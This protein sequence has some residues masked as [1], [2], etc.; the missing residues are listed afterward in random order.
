MKRKP[1]VL[2]DAFHLTNA[3]TG[4]RTY[5]TQLCDGI[6]KN[7]YEE[8]E[9]LI[10]PNWR[11]LNKT[12]LLRGKVNVFKKIINHLLYLL[13]KQ[14]CLPLI[15]LF[16]RIDVIVAPDYLLPFFKFKSKSLAVFH[17]T[18]YWELKQNYNPLWRNYF[19]KSVMFGL[20]V[21]TGIVVTS[22]F[23]ANKVEQNVSKDYDISV[24]YQAPKNLA[25]SSNELLN[26]KKIGLPEHAKYFLH[27]GVL[28]KRKN[29][30]ILITA[31]SKICNDEFF[32]D[33]H[34]LLI[35]SRAVTWFH[36]DFNNLD[37]L[38]K[39][40]NLEQRVIMPGFVS[41]NELSH[42]YK[43]AFAYVFPSKEEGFGIPVIE[44]MKSNIPVVISDQAALK[45]VAGDAALVF[46]M[47]SIESLSG[48]LIKL[49]SQALREALIEKGKLR[50]QKFTQDA[51]VNSFHQVVMKKINTG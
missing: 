27:V 45:E 29:L 21:E 39:L 33:H 1:R 37:K 3:L 32:K 49:K 42:I 23:V 14:F 7:E 11:W 43:K 25:I 5:T 13:W 18:F 50:S 47:N 31:F 22:N 36:D 9:Y 34:L 15:I 35:G 12:S 46:E 38:I 44:A 41:D 20:N 51:F 2:I 24:V 8:V 16:K 26:Y 19:L 17:D 40:Y 10:Y 30:D 28:D 48:E 6:E 4:I